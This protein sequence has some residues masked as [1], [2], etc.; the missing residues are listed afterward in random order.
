MIFPPKQVSDARAHLSKV[1]FSGVY[2][3]DF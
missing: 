3:T 1:S 2:I